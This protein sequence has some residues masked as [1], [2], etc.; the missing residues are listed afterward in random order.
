MDNKGNKLTQEILKKFGFKKEITK[1]RDGDEIKIWH[2]NGISIYEDSWW[3]TELNENGELLQHA[4]SSYEEDEIPPEITFDFAT[5]VKGDGSFKGG[6][7]IETDQQVKNI[8][9]SLSNTELQ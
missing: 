5:Y 2:K 1:D 4:M 9:Y 7:S 3:L 8:Y 6:F